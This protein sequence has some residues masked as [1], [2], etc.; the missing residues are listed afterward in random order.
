MMMIALLSGEADLNFQGAVAALPI[1]RLG[2]VRA[3]AVTSLKRSPAA[4][5]VP[6]MD[7]FYPGLETVNWFALF[8]PAGTAT[9]VT[10]KLS[11]AVRKELKSP[12]IESFLTREGLEAVGSTPAEVNT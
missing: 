3:L 6:T 2:K 11:T 5:D 8:A 7:S 4:P 10:A 9:G 1:M 12:E